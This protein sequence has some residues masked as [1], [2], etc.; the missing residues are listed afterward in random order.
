MS[1]LQDE[2][3]LRV[4]TALGPD[5]FVLRRLSVV[6]ALE[7]P[8]VIQGELIAADPETEIGATDILGTTIT[9]SIVWAQR[10]L[11][12]HFHGVVSAFGSVDVAQRGN[13]VYRFEAVPA[14]WLLT[15]T[16]DCRIFQ[17]KSVQQIIQSV[18]DERGVGSVTFTHMPSGTRP[19]CTQ[20][21]ESDFDFIHRLLDEIG[22]TF[23]FE[24]GESTDGWTITGDAAGF[25]TA[26]GDPLVVRGEPDRPNAVTG[27]SSFFV[28]QP[29][30]HKNWD[31]DNLKPS[32]QPMAEAPT[33]LAGSD[34]TANLKLYRWPGGQSVRPDATPGTA[35]LRMRRHEAGHETW[36]GRSEAALLSPGQKVQ[37]QVGVAGSPESWLVTAVTH[38]A[39]DETHA[40]GGSAA[41]YSNSFSCIPAS[42]PWRSPVHRP[43][44]VVAGVQSAIVTGPAGEEQHCDEYGRVKVHFLWDHRDDKKDETSSC[45]V[46]VMQPFGGAWGGGWFLP[47]IGDEVL[48]AFQGGDPDRP[49]IVGSLYNADG[50][51]PWTLPG[52]ITRSGFRSRSTKTGDR[53]TANILG[54]DDKK[55]SEQLYLQ[56][57]KDYLELVKNQKKVTVQGNEIREVTGSSQDQSDG[58]RTTTIKGDE[59]LEVKQ[60]NR[61]ATISMGNETL[62][63]K[64]GNMEVKVSLGNITIKA[65]L[66]SITMEALQGITLKGGPTSSIE[67]APAGITL[68]ALKIDTNADLMNQTKGAIEQQ[69]GSGMQKIGG[70]ITMIG[71]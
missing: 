63:V 26:E 8:Y 68:K 59:T 64:M 1:L 9:C 35:D 39:H 44:P 70:A 54:F 37:V 15:R 7:Q 57:Q 53:S 36:S 49:V 60:G 52:H 24:H 34:L 33:A 14:F 23:F 67:I 61:A 62:T 31:F 28:V 11:T 3:L 55:D 4:K 10:G 65:D 69:S 47:R 16:M 6:E 32:Q 25:P 56:A 48:V 40:T 2:R 50:K 41:A 17:E 71:G 38:D 66:G 21:N 29:A 45:Y 20:Y 51:P 27:W 13:R 58:K 43:R 19:Y 22:G 18:V 12:R 5:L 30:G 46:R 42:R